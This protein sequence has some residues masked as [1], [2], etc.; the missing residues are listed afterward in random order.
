MVKTS[1]GSEER[2]KANAFIRAIEPITQELGSLDSVRLS[3][4]E[5][6]ANTILGYIDDLWK[7]EDYTY[8]QERMD[9]LLSLTSNRTTCFFLIA[10]FTRSTLKVLALRKLWRKSLKPLDFG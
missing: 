5:D 4:I 3:E 8:P 6:S 10:V 9:H 2:K 7:L 1:Q